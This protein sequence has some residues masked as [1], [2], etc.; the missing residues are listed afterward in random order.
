MDEAPV[1]IRP[2]HFQESVP[3]ELIAQV[4]GLVALPSPYY[5]RVV[6]SSPEDDRVE[7]VRSPTALKLDGIAEERIVELGRPVL[8]L[9]EEAEGMLEV[10]RVAAN[11]AVY[12]H[13][14]I[15]LEAVST[16]GNLN[17]LGKDELDRSQPRPR[18]GP[19]CSSGSRF[20]ALPQRGPQRP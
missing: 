12:A 3:H 9:E 14:A 2:P 16:A 11:A 20:P 5:P 18:S 6:E 7:L 19:S 8:A 17:S 13:A 10:L 1:R 4:L 15:D